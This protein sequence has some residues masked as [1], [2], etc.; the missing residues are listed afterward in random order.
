MADNPYA[1]YDFGDETPDAGTMES[2]QDVGAQG[3]NRLK[4]GV[5][6]LPGI[7]GDVDEIARLAGNWL[8]RNTRYLL[9]GEEGYNKAVENQKRVQPRRLTEGL[10]PTSQE[11][12]ESVGFERRK[13][14]TAAGKAF[15]ESILGDIMEGV[16]GAIGSA[17]MAVV[18]GGVRAVVPNAA[19]AVLRYDV[20]PRT[21]GKGVETAVEDHLAPGWGETAGTLASI[22]TAGIGGYREMPK[23]VDITRDQ[24]RREG[25]DLFNQARAQGVAFS[26]PAIKTL[27]SDI[28]QEIRRMGSSKKSHPEATS[29]LREIKRRAAQPGP[30]DYT[31]YNAIREW[32]SDA[33][34][35]ALHNPGDLKRI[36]RITR[37]LDRFMEKPPAG[38]F[39]GNPTKAAALAKKA[40]SLWQRQHKVAIIE[41]ALANIRNASPRTPE[42]VAARTA[43]RNIANN[44]NLMQ[45]FSPAERAAIDEVVRAGKFEK[46]MNFFSR[47]AISSGGIRGLGLAAVGHHLGGLEGLVAAAGTP[48]VAKEIVTN[49][50]KRSIKKVDTMVRRGDDIK[51]DMYPGAKKA[52]VTGAYLAGE[53]SRRS[54]PT[55]GGNPYLQYDFGN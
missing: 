55:P 20:A 36:K 4:E 54:R 31:D 26:R 30:M 46:L 29:L 18:K 33:T 40:R 1:A 38:A 12:K 28:D 8:G 15:D 14:K 51:I 16:P 17:P 52:A 22:A 9:E 7:A 34:G 6:D 13:P 49:M 25:S 27:A 53:P 45:Q 39:V 32:A 21:V 2:L 23:V 42:D 3:L 11:F 5:L 24:I 10:L 35:A 47:W 50:T 41:K 44:D 48:E 43:F 37:I 19:K